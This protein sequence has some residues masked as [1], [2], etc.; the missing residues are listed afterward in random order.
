VVKTR[1]ANAKKERRQI[2]KETPCKLGW[3]IRREHATAISVVNDDAIRLGKP[4]VCDSQH[5]RESH[6][7]DEISRAALINCA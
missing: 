2:R 4:G 6:R 1:R 5:P 3:V 7:C